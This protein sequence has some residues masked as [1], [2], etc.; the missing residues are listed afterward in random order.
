[1][2]FFYSVVRREGYIDMMTKI[3]IAVAL[4]IPASTYAATKHIECTQTTDKDVV[5]TVRATLDDTSDKAEVQFFATSAD[6]AKSDSCEINIFK[7]DVLP[8]VIRLTSIISPGSLSYSTTID[9]DR[10]SLDV[11]THTLLTGSG[12]NSEST[13][14]GKCSVKVVKSKNVL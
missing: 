11:V 4:V 3:L 10:A 9:I 12:I 14:H 6:C 7:K 13:A 2:G 8:S 1:M 5:Q